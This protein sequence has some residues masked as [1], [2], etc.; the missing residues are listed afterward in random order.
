MD[1][2]P[3]SLALDSPLVR[4]GHLLSPHTHPQHKNQAEN[5]LESNVMDTHSYDDFDKAAALVSKMALSYGVT[6][7]A[8]MECRGA[9]AEQSPLRASDFLVRYKDRY[10]L[11]IEIFYQTTECKRALEQGLKHIGGALWQYFEGK[12]D[13]QS[14][15]SAMRA[16]SRMSSS[17]TDSPANLRFDSTVPEKSM[18]CCGI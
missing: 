12:A 6:T 3:V 2:P 14:A 16:A 1:N 13:A 4:G 17:V 8:A 7:V 11:T 18:P 9:Q 15:L 10:P 5:R